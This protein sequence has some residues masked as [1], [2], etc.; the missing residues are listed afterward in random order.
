MPIFLTAALMAVVL[1]ILIARRRKPAGKFT[2]RSPI[3]DVSAYETLVTTDDFDEMVL[4]TSFKTPVLVDFFATWCQ[5]CNYFA[6]ILSAF[7]DRY[8]GSFLLAKVDVDKNDLLLHR[9][10]IEA[11]PTIMLFKN[12]ECVD[13]FVGGRLPHSIRYFLASNGVPEPVEE[14]QSLST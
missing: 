2:K 6:P 10:D 3:K 11:M 14:N 1:G 9:Y 12:G 13:R 7:A 4:D 8:R 5:P